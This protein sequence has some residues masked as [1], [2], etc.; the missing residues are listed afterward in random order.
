MARI[1]AI[2]DDEDALLYVQGVL[3]KDHDVMCVNSWM[4]ASE[5]LIRQPFDLVL[6]DVDMPG[7]SGD[8]LAE[9]LQRR[10]KEHSLSIVLFS[11]L[12]EAELER[13]AANVGAKGFIRKPCP[14]DLFAL[15][16]K[17]FLR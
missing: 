15:R 5:A 13:K 6:L 14:R 1:L 16:V 8:K 7:L 9:I 4:K 11:G 12:D 3:S 2:D 17:R 10:F